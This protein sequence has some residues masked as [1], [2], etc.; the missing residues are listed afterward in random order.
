MGSSD[1]VVGGRW[2]GVWTYYSGFMM[3]VRA[4]NGIMSVFDGAVVQQLAYR[5]CTVL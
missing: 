2:C 3:G 5:E 4:V 1:A